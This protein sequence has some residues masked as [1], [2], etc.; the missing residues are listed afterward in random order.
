MSVSTTAFNEEQR[1]AI[2]AGGVVFVSAGAGT[3][4]T[5]VLVERFARAVLDRGLSP[6]RIL[7]IT[8]TERA[9][10]ELA[11]RI[12]VRLDEE[13]QRRAGAGARRR[14]DL[15]HP[16]LLRPHPAPPRAAG[17]ARP[18]VRGARSRRGRPDARG[19][20][21][22]RAAGDGGEPRGRAR[23]RHGLRRGPAAHAHRRHPRAAAHR[24]ASAAVR[25]RRPPPACPTRSPSARDGRAGA[26]AQSSAPACGWTSRGRARP[27]WPSCSSTRPSPAVLAALPDHASRGRLEV[28]GDYDAALAE[29]ERAA[30]DAVFE[31]LRPLLD[32]LLQAFA[33][34]YAGRKRAAS[35][36]D[37]DDLQL[38]ARRVLTER[39]DVRAD[40]QQRFAEVMVDEF[41]D[42]NELQCAIVDAVAGPD[43]TLFFVGDEF[44][45]IYRFRHADVAVFRRRR[46]EVRQG[47]GEGAISLRT[48]YRSRP[49]VLAVVNHLFG[50]A[51][52]PTYEPL[53]PSD[54]AFPELR[55]GRARGRV[56]RHRRLRPGERDRAARRRGGD[57][58]EAHRAAGG[59]GLVQRRRRGA[60]V[61]RRHRRGA[62][63]A[64]PAGGRPG[65]RQRHRPQVLRG[66]AGARRHGLP[67]ADPQPLRRRRV[68]RGD[69]LAAGRRLQRHA[70]APAHER[71]EAA[72]L[73][74]G[75]ERHPD[76]RRSRRR[77]AAGGVPAAVRPARR[78][79]RPQQPGRAGRAHRRR[80]RLR[81][82][83]A[84]EPLR[85]A[86]ARQ[87]AQAGAPG[88]RVRGAPRPRPGGLPRDRR[89]A[90][91]GGRPRAR[92]AGVGGGR[93]RRAPD[94]GARREGPPVPGRGGGRR[95]ARRGRSLRP[96]G[97]AARRPGRHQGARLGRPAARDERLHRGVAASTRWRRTPSAAASPTS[98]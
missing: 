48:N 21:R 67:A 38:E 29:L 41:Q 68:P 84:R 77:A 45:S 55:A 12:R 54:G 36:L 96:P 95:R 53:Q 82:G 73:H 34:E 43:A 18:G 25:R 9:A 28:A 17:R 87:R 6:D 93:R 14:L 42:T 86:P 51:F 8:Y 3:G 72:A 13:G 78:G 19:V 69:R 85:P 11:A 5:R 37:F 56:P 65:H 39:D 58:R 40:L 83:A 47:D 20:V 90:P 27:P 2:E 30:R 66:P 62:L 15:D 24:R 76:H 97:R 46:D 61:L 49:E 60:A 22:R 63:R 74:V 16:R 23:P 44:Q 92:R 33:A 50:D 80:P 57:A 91:A 32:D 1:R 59:R 98:P 79:G 7:A 64:G 89:G 70:R 35:C 94:D 75:R 26:G 71:P 10:A 88:A 4:K 81:P 31:S 52:G